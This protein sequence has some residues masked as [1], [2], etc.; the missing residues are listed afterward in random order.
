MSIILFSHPRSGSSHFCYSIQKHLHSYYK[1]KCLFLNEFLN[2]GNVPSFGNVRSYINGQNNLTV[3]TLKDNICSLENL[4]SASLYETSIVNFTSN[5][6]FNDWC[7]VELEK[8]INFI[9]Y[10]MT[11]NFHFVMKHFF[12]IDKL[13]LNKFDNRLISLAK[14]FNI[15]WLLY[16]Q[17]LYESIMS[18]LI[19]D[20]YFDIPDVISNGGHNPNNKMLP[21]QPTNKTINVDK[22]RFQIRNQIEIFHFQ[23]LHKLDKVMIYEELINGKKIKIIDEVTIDF[24]SNSKSILYP[25]NYALDKDHYF[26]NSFVVKEVINEIVK[27]QKLESYLKELEIIW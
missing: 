19:K 8:R 18:R 12:I 13:L 3:L 16:R 20:Y 5:K 23:K 7:L 22:L 14:K 6:Q 17:N 27:E 24:S 25:M 15:G 21:L 11:T 26:E 1:E 9:E 2:I 10:L 4:N